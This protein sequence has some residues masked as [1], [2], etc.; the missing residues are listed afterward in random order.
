MLKLLA[1]TSLMA[2]LTIPVFAQEPA[3]SRMQNEPPAPGAE[4][5]TAAPQ[6]DAITT[7]QISA[8]DLLNE[9]VKNAA[10]ETIGDVN[11]VLVAQDGKSV[12]VV[13]G[14]GGFLGIGEKD[15][16]LSFDKLK[17][18]QDNDG[19]L[20]VTTDATK[21]SLQAAPEYRKPDTKD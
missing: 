20:V 15:V 10:D 17:F 14:A 7:G 21:E 6:R 5:S 18:A 4:R 8:S 9:P 1:G 2:L 19:D 3:P 11:D 16:V 13:V 12:S